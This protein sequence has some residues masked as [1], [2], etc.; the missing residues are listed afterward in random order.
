[1]ALNLDLKTNRYYKF[2]NIVDE[3]TLKTY[4]ILLSLSFPFN[5]GGYQ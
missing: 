5:I 3:N 4:D 1:M 2:E